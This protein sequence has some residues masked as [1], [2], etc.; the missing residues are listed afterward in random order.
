MGGQGKVQLEGLGML[1]TLETV[2]FA[3]IAMKMRPPQTKKGWVRS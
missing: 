1:K 2:N 3:V